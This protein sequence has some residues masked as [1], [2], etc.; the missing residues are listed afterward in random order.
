MNLADAIDVHDRRAVDAREM[1]RIELLLEIGERQAQQMLSRSLD[2][3]DIVARRLDGLEVFGLHEND[4]ATIAHRESSREGR[5][6]GASGASLLELTQQL[7]D[8]FAIA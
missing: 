6:A 1:C 2:E 7:V 4:S 8:S 3:Q 5:G